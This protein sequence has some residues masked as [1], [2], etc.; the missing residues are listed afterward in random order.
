MNHHT[1]STHSKRRR[2]L[3][4]RWF[5]SYLIIALIPL[6]TG[7]GIYARAKDM[8]AQELINS[9]RV[10][11]QQLRANI[12]THFSEL[13]T[14]VF[15]LKNVQ[16]LV[17]LSLAQ[18]DLSS[19]QIYTSY[20]LSNTLRIYRTANEFIEEVSVY[21][22]RTNCFVTS[23]GKYDPSTYFSTYIKNRNI[24]YEQWLSILSESS[25]SPRLNMDLGMTYFCSLNEQSRENRAVI[26]IKL[27]EKFLKSYFLTQSILQQG[28]ILVLT[29]NNEE[30]FTRGENAANLKTLLA[31]DAQAALKPE[32]LYTQMV[33][34]VNG[35]R[36]SF[37]F[38]YAQVT[39]KNHYIINYTLA[40]TGIAMGLSVVFAWLFSHIQYQPISRLLNNVSRQS[41][42]LAANE[43]EYQLLERHIENLFCDQADMKAQLV[44]QG[45]ALGLENLR[46][47]LL[48]INY[49][50]EADNEVL[51][52]YG[53]VFD[54]D[55][56]RVATVAA[57]DNRIRDNTFLLKVNALFT[58]TFSHDTVYTL[59][60]M[61]TI[62]CV[63]NTAKQEPPAVDAAKIETI[64]QKLAQEIECT[65]WISVSLYHKELLTLPAA[66]A[67]STRALEQRTMSEDG[68][69][70]FYDEG[71]Q[72]TAFGGIYYPNG[73]DTRLIHIL[74]SGDLAMM[75]SCVD[76]IID[77][78]LKR[79]ITAKQC[80]YLGYHLCMSFLKAS[81][82]C[83]VLYHIDLSELME[84]MVHSLQIDRIS[85]LR[86][87]YIA[88]CES[89]V[90][91]ISQADQEHE[92]TLVDKITDCVLEN[93]MD[94]NL[95]VNTISS[96]L[97][98]NA[99]YISRTFA[100]KTGQ[101]LSAYLQQIRIKASLPLICAGQPIA[102][103][104][105]HT[106][107]TNITTFNR[108]FKKEMG[109]T[110]G[111]YREV[112]RKKTNMYKEIEYQPKSTN[113][114]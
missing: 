61:D 52:H 100:E 113:E 50:T 5:L 44:S 17:S 46:R 89:L 42:T 88:I 3:M 12:D 56:F 41:R 80:T 69:V 97:A 15:Q 112:T 111:A 13:N 36:Y 58:E 39:Q 82:E 62:C 65:L 85:T 92:D 11:L 21:Y 84:R 93:Y 64:W 99:S 101:T 54:G 23:T 71:K 86:A 19:N 70:V 95:N 6:A 83:Q 31:E 33:S 16:E 14:L 72:N 98:M 77:Q 29:A 75:R 45:M 78:N 81:K 57:S 9:H 38:P 53:I 114:V 43:S 49:A 59:Q 1:V 106:G 26:L 27:D 67:E 104:M 20:E 47:L 55:Y 7:L 48:G 28:S 37:L 51:Q 105:A 87:H 91:A 4:W 30:V 94:P 34:I 10:F 60:V 66:Y 96:Q 107:Y 40:I 24:S 63:I 90:E 18:G 108:A 68:G 76:E 8:L 103:V 102:E 110:P 79:S 35:W 22:P 32:Y 25:A 109:T 74:C 2:P 73:F